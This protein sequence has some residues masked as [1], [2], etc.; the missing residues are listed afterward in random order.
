[1]PLVFTL[2]GMELEGVLVKAEELREYGEKLGTQIARLEQEIY[3]LAGETFNINS[4]K[5][6][7]D[8]V[9]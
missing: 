4:P 2:Y 1:M 3:E 9:V 8:A 6:L 7:G 5:Q